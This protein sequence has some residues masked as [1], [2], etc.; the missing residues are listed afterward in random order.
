MVMNPSILK[1]SIRTGG[2][3]GA[4][5]APPSQQPRPAKTLTR[6]VAKRS[7]FEVERVLS[8]TSSVER[9]E[10]DDQGIINEESILH[11]AL[12]YN[13]PLEIVRLLAKKPDSTGKFACHVAGKYGATPIVMEY[14]IS[15]N[16]AAAGVQDPQG[17]A[18]IHYVA[19]FYQGSH[20]SCDVSD[21][22][23]QVVRLLREA[24][25]LSFN[26][27]D[28]D[29]CNAI[30]Y[31]IENDA[32]IRVVK[33]MQ[34]TARDDWRALKANGQG[35]KH[36]DLAKDIEQKANEARLN[37]TLGDV[38]SSFKPS[39]THDALGRRRHAMKRSFAAKTA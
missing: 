24:A 21:A 22:M 26:L 28:N 13:A 4:R 38:V 14:L 29:G 7:W 12:R 32:D 1:S 25:P 17:K 20:S 6:L 5:R 15:R 16:K 31:A 37:L 11:F 18:P 34:R 36:E 33:T 10:I 30:E 3:V 39:A 19:E 9:I 35:K 2:I 8:S 27:E 23:L